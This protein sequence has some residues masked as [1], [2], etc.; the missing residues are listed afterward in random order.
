LRFLNTSFKW[1]S[2]GELKEKTKNG[3]KISM[4]HNVPQHH[5]TL[6]CI[7]VQSTRF[8]WNTPRYLTWFLSHW[9]TVLAF[10]YCTWSL[11]FTISST[12]VLLR[13]LFVMT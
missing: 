13:G 4:W 2:I 3:Q 9:C 1:A 6:N 7:R 5:S 12:I 11:S 10:Q 8:T